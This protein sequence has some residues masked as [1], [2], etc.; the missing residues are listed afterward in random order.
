MF[1]KLPGQFILLLHVV[2]IIFLKNRSAAPS[3]KIVLQTPS[4]PTNTNMHYRKRKN[5]ADYSYYLY[6]I[7]IFIYKHIVY[8]K[9]S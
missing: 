4:S 9:Q 2:I 7:D 8:N 1:T 3:K 5:P 6:I